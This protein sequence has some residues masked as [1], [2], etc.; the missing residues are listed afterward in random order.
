[1]T[2]LLLNPVALAEATSPS[3][4]TVDGG[5]MLWTLFVFGLLLYLLKRSAWPVLLRAVRDREERLEK[6]IAEAERHRAEAAALLEEHRK[7]LAGAKTEAQEILARAH[8]VAEK[9]HAAL[10]AKAREEADEQLARARRDIAD[11]K[12]KAIL[13]LRREAVDLSIAAA[14]KLIESQ[15]DSDA[16]RRLVSEYLETLGSR[17]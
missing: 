8:G 14:S 5:L 13:E 2:S 17:S 10:V 16:N 15:L 9:E 7:L 4:L 6:Q 11:E 3:P 1:M 12:A